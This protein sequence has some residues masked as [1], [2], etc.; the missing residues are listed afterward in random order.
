[1]ENSIIRTDVAGL[2]YLYKTNAA[3][4]FIL[5]SLSKRRNNWKITTITSLFSVFQLAG[6]E[7]SRKEII[8]T[9]RELERMNFCEF[10]LGKVAGNRNGQSRIVWKIPLGT[11]GRIAV[12]KI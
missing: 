3:A 12:S 5:E 8:S 10:I 6:L 2:R 1:M 9:A 11:V 7:I 4:R